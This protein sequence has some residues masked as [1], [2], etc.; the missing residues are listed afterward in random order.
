[1]FTIGMSWRTKVLLFYIYEEG[2]NW[3][4]IKEGNVSYLTTIKIRWFGLFVCLF[5]FLAVFV[6][7]FVLFCFV[8]LFA[9]IVLIFFVCFLFVLFPFWFLI[10]SFIFVVLR[11]FFFSF[12]FFFFV[13]RKEN[14]SM[15][16]ES[17]LVLKTHCIKTY[18][19]LPCFALCLILLR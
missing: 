16:R 2:L 17:L 7:V 4:I 13:C 10:L 6:W 9:C 1:M 3:K 12:S 11:V 15:F 14:N 18:T 5:F 8:P 19:L